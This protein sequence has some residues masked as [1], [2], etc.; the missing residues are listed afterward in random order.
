[1][2]NIKEE[3]C[4]GCKSCVKD[5]PGAAIKME[6][7]KAQIVKKCIQCGHCVAICPVNA[8][9]IPE[10]DME[11]VEEYEKDSF[12][13]CPENFLHAVKFRRSV[14]N[15]KEQQIEEDKIKR[16]LEAGRYTATA[17]NMQ[18]CTYIFVQEKLSEFK[19]LVWKEIPEIIERL[20][21]TN[22]DYAVGFQYFYRKWSKN[23]EDDTFFFNTPAF[24]AVT[25]L[26]PLDGGLSS[27]N[28]E[29][30]A[31]AE[32]LGVLYSG[33]MVRVIKSSPVLREWLG[34]EEKEISCCLL[35]GYPA[36]SY[37][38]TAPRHKADI[39]WK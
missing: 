32:G 38:R 21:E 27:A 13:V 29:N 24:L 28:I 16:V 18:D 11:D 9:S 10:Y 31:V 19:E 17:K 4:I 23:P 33:Y 12:T 2:V 3:L 26:N 8:V 6:G 22:P 1:M 34:I 37:K 7:N 35:M 25:S 15:F 5:C 30:M 39:V 14:R 36:V 20:K